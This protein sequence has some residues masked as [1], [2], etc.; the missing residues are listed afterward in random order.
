MQANPTPGVVIF[1][2]NSL[3][4]FANKD[5][6]LTCLQKA[7]KINPGIVWLFANFFNVLIKLKIWKTDAKDKQGNGAAKVSCSKSDVWVI[8]MCCIFFYVNV[9]TSFLLK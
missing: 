2:F 8:F 4:F 7:T 1:K 6:F 5:Y 3:L 9:K